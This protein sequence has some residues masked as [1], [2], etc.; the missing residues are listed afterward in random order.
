VKTPIVSV[1]RQANVGLFS[2][3][4]SAESYLEAIDIADGEYDLYD[5]DALVLHGITEVKSVQFGPVEWIPEGRWKLTQ[6]DPPEYRAD[7]LAV[8]LRS[9]LR[10]ISPKKRF[11][12]DEWVEQATLASL[13]V[14]AAPFATR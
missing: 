10:G 2:L 13:L 12:P 3:V 7:A 11:R 14:E 9:F 4:A 1:D 5:A 6:S 8:A